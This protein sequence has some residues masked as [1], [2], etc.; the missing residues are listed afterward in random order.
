MQTLIGNTRCII[1]GGCVTCVQILYDLV[2]EKDEGISSSKLYRDTKNPT[3]INYE[4]VSIHIPG[5]LC[6]CQHC[7]FTV[8]KGLVDVVIVSKKL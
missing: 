2:Y 7:V 6:F 1:G 4:R 8:L 3:Q 5:S